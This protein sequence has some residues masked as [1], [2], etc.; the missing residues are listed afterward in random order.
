MLVC[1]GPLHTPASQGGL[2]VV[3]ELLKQRQTGTTIL[4]PLPPNPTV[5]HSSLSSFKEKKKYKPKPDN[6]GKV[7][8][9]EFF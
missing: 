2:S 6:S 4:I 9:L 7:E 3:R 8:T 1:F 5:L